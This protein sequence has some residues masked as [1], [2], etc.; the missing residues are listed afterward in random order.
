MYFALY[1]V[2]HTILHDQE[3]WEAKKERFYTTDRTG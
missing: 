3:Y 1:D 2:Y